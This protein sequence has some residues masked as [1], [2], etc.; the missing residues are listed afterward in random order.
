MKIQVA[1]V[2]TM[3]VAMFFGL[4]GFVG[5]VAVGVVAKDQVLKLVALVKSKLAKKN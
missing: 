1:E 2:F 5:G 4:I 3:E